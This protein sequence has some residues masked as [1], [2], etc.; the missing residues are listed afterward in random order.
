MRL[1][2]Y[3]EQPQLPL[4]PGFE[5]FIAVLFKHN[6]K[7]FKKAANLV[8]EI[9]PHAH[10]LSSGPENGADLVIWHGRTGHQAETPRRGDIHF[11]AVPEMREK[12]MELG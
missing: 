6:S 4:S 9:G 1:Q 3:P 5:R 11:M 2:E 10:Q 8:A 7:D 12:E